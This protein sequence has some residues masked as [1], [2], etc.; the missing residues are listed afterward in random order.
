MHHVEGVAAARVVHVVPRI[1][2]HGAVVRQ[3]VD[4]AERRVGTRLVAFRRVVVD[5]VQ[6]DFDAGVV[7]NLDHFL[8][9]SDRSRAAHRDLTRSSARAQRSRACC[10][11][12]NC[13]SP[14]RPGAGRAGKACTGMSSS[15]VTPK[16]SQM[17]DDGLG[18]HPRVRAAQVSG[19]L[20]MQPRHAA[21]VGLVDERFVPPDTRDGSRPLQS[22]AG[23]IT[24]AERCERRAIAIVEATDRGWGRRAGSRTVRRP[25]LAC[26][27]MTLA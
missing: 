26:R 25:T 20:R 3:V 2:R 24:A 16:L 18:R 21:H 13:A 1:A 15:A 6:D 12:S 8:E 4:A 10:S 23:S 9:L 14:C 22:K 19:H 5:H 7:Q 11:P 17:L 27:P